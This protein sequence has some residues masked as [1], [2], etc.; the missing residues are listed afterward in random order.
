MIKKKILISV[1]LIF[2]CSTISF[3]QE[4]P[5]WITSLENHLKQKETDWKIERKT[6]FASLNGAY[7]YSFILKSGKYQVSILIM[8]LPD[9]NRVEKAVENAFAKMVDLFSKGIYKN[10][11]RAKIENF[12]DEGFIWTDLKIDDLPRTMMLFR[13][14]DVFV[15]INTPS[16]EITKKFARYIFER[17]P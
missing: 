1:F 6:E 4:K 14:Q 2:L 16:E 12:G 7:N 15:Q 3:G 10:A 13:K 17:M 5:I 8:K 9:G 11:K